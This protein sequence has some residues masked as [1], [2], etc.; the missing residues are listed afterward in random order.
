[1]SNSKTVRF[2]LPTLALALATSALSANSWQPLSTGWTEQRIAEVLVRQDQFR[3]FPKAGDP[4]W[5][6]VPEVVR[7][8]TIEAAEKSLAR[9]WPSLPATL[10]L[11]FAR[12]GTRAAY[13]AKSF[14]RR[15]RLADL[16][17]AEAIENKGRF[18]DAIADGVWSICE[19]TFWGVPA[20]LGMQKADVGLPDVQE[21]VVDLFAAETGATLAWAWYL[22]GDRLQTVSPLIGPRIAY[23]IDRRILTPN[24]QRDDFWWMGFGGRS[25][26]NWNPW[27]NSNWLATVLL[28]EP[29]EVRRAQAVAKIVRSLDRF[30]AG[31]PD[32]G[33]CDEGP[34]YW[35][36]AGASLFD[37]L[38]LLHSA[39]RGELNV[40]NDP[41]AQNIGRY[42]YRVHIG[43]DWFVDFADASAKASPDPALVF[44]Y[45]KAIQDPDMLRFGAYLAKRQGWPDKG[46]PS[47]MGDLGRRLPALFSLRALS[48]AEPVAPLPRDSWLSGLQVMVARDSGG[49]DRGFF[50][51]AKGG[52]N[53]ESHNHNDV[54]NF[55]VFYDADPV[56]IDAGVGTY[57]AKTFS[58]ERY[59]IWTMQSA[60]HNL[61]T[62][63]GVMQSDGRQFAARSVRYQVDDDRVQ[64]SLDLAGAYPEQAGLQEMLRDFE[65]KRGSS[66]IVTDRFQTTAGAGQGETYWTLMTASEPKLAGPGRVE[67]T[68]ASGKRLEIVYQSD[69]LKPAVEM[70]NIDDPRLSGSWGARLWRLLLRRTDGAVKGATRI[71]I[72]ASE[73]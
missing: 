70:I 62:F 24:L 46:A 2:L 53:A 60:Y 9:E 58:P 7:R 15:G 36:R 16:V 14:E 3:P 28:V 26:N 12:T 42:I 30:L 73:G 44:R 10:F 32:D 25:V 4:R 31:Y 56:I 50:L 47:R 27:I 23:E 69:V 6:E 59:S 40:F 37:C 61:P 67:L 29:S 13:E 66:V 38:E 43:N 20:H 49:S 52:H 55:I 19:E 18:L 22:V 64:F 41:L 57:T 8:K 48:E 54:G 68:T 71:E 21:P 17:L 1:M 5:Q 11:D 51:A 34:S 65:F 45:G 72:R 33:G 35:G 39:T 63:Q